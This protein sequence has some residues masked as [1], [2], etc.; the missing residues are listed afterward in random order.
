MAVSAWV[1]APGR[2]DSLY[3]PVCLSNLGIVIC[4]V[5]SPLPLIQESLLDCLVCSVFICFQDGMAT[6]NLL[7]VELE[8]RNPPRS[9]FYLK[10]WGFVY[11]RL[12]VLILS[13]KINIALIYISH[14]DDCFPP[15]LCF[16]YKVHSTLTWP[17]F[18][19]WMEVP[20][21]NGF[22]HFYPL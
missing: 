17:L 19:H 16:I 8:I 15:P 21:F 11:H 3:S 14:L 9:C 7:R 12:F 4:P 22:Y 20:N 6:S 1:S 13:L 10:F 18:W 2:C 5:S